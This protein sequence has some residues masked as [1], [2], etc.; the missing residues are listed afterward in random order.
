MVE[1]AAK[2][3]NRIVTPG[4]IALTQH[5]FFAVGLRA[6]ANCPASSSEW[7]FFQGRRFE[8]PVIVS[9]ISTLGLQSP[10]DLGTAI[11]FTTAVYKSLYDDKFLGIAHEFPDLFDNKE[12]EM[13]AGSLLLQAVGKPL[14]DPDALCVLTPFEQKGLNLWRVESKDFANIV[15]PVVSVNQDLYFQKRHVFYVADPEQRQAH[16][17]DIAICRNIPGLNRQP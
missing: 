16:L 1:Q 8:A 17:S 11:K 10:K 13:P 15:K 14:N 6:L 3:S 5:F 2:D 7:N 12:K 9:G 4:T